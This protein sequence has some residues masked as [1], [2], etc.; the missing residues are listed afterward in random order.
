MPTKEELR[1]L[2]LGPLGPPHVA[3]QALALRD[4]GID[5][6]VGGNASAELADSSL[7]EAGLPVFTSPDSSRA[8]PWGMAATIRWT[9]RTIDAVQPHVVHAHWLPGFGFAAA[10]ARASPLA[11]TA[12]GSDVYR[13]SPAQKVANRYALNRADLVMADS[14]DLL[15][16][17]GPPRGNELRTEIIQWGADLSTFRPADAEERAEL[18]RRLG[19][20][21]GP[22]ILSPRTL[23]PVYNI[24]T[25]IE[26]FGR[27]GD[28]LPDA[29][30]VLKHM[31]G[32]TIELPPFPHPERM[33]LIGRVPYDQMADYYRCADVCV[34]ITSSDSSPRSVWEAMG[35][36]CA[37]VLSDLPW[38]TELIEPGR[39]AIT[40]PVDATAVAEAVL[41]VLTEPGLHDRLAA[42]GRAL[43]ERHLDRDRE[44]DRL[45]ALYIGLA[46]G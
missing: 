3:D 25:V 15:D 14:K 21:P 13:A 35:A 16:A 34:S 1:I 29:Q 11:L 19:L 27:V 45:A 22:V 32:A 9:R 33:H 10:V 26:A 41:R 42:N 30:L 39:D 24:P 12:W 40:V 43:V 2:L 8:T 31:G 28:A 46:A 7:A 6:H 36:G 4:R 18:R 44:M 23:M 38:V 5:V 17:C 20:G 37:C